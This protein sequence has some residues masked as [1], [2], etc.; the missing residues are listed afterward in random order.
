MTDRERV[1]L[2]LKE[3]PVHSTELRREGYTGNPSQRINE[4]RE[5]GFEIKAEPMVWTDANGKQRNGAL[6]TLISEPGH[7]LGTGKAAADR[8][9]SAP[10]DL[11]R[12]L[13]EPA[14]AEPTAALFSLP[15]AEP[16]ASY[17]DPDAEAA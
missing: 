4:L 16:Q 6:Y 3:G 7:G 2:R 5:M 10:D 12:G 17:R 14:S 9:A 1:L 8:A 13:R 11:P 15:E